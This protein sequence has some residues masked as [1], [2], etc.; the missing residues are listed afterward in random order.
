MPAGDLAQ[1]VPLASALKVRLYLSLRR[2]THV[3][4]RLATPACMRGS[5]AN[6]VNGNTRKRESSISQDQWFT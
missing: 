1:V 5:F 3:D 2:L 6:L 4:N